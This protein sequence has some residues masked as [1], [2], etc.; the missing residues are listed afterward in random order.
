D[1]L[2]PLIDGEVEVV[3]RECP[4]VVD[5]VGEQEAPRAV[6]Q[7]AQPLDAALELGVERVL[8]A[9]LPFAVGRDEAEQ[10]PCELA[11]RIVASAFALDV[12]PADAQAMRLRR[13]LADALGLFDGDLPLE[14]GE[15]AAREDAPLDL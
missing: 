15:A 14:P 1:E 11:P 4:L 12:E 9:V 13:E 8:E 2:D 7:P 5:A 6:P 10:G 3:T